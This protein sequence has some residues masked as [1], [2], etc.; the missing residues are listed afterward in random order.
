MGRNKGFSSDVH[1]VNSPSVTVSSVYIDAKL[2]KK[3]DNLGMPGT[4]S[5]VKSS[6]AFIVRLTGIL[7]L[8]RK[9]SDRPIR[10]YEADK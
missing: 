3:L 9:E 1:L 8:G 10:V 2:N 5:V 7:N 4:H 6:D